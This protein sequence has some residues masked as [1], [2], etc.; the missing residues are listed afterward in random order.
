MTSSQPHRVSSGHK[1][2]RESL[3][4]PPRKERIERVRDRES[5]RLPPRKEREREKMPKT[6]VRRTR[7][8][9]SCDVW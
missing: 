3:S 2:A 8:V 5:L 6:Q 4:L 1:R 7:G 9:R